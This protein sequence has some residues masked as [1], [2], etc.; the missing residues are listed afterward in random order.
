MLIYKR[1]CQVDLPGGGHEAT[2]LEM[3]AM[4]R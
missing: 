3:R 2:L 1:D 4:E